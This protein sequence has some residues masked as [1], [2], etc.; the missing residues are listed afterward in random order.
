MTPFR[1]LFREP[2][3]PAGERHHDPRSSR[4]PGA[5]AG[6]RRLH[7]WSPGD[8][9][10][11]V[12]PRLL[13][14]VATWSGYDLHLLDLLED[15][16]DIPAR[17]DVF[18]I[19]AVPDP[20]NWDNYYRYIPGFT[21]GSHTPFVGLWHDGTLVE[22]ASGYPAR[23]LVARVCHLDGATLHQSFTTHTRQ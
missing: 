11:P 5:V 16:P 2:L 3:V 19:D 1:R 9:I 15:A 21:P 8:P 20:T 14:G 13:V 10:S 18:D 12:G 4:F 7:L 6:S 22:S 17:L 23:E